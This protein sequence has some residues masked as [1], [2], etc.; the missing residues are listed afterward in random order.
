MIEGSARDGRGSVYWG[1]VG[2]R[3]SDRG[4]GGVGSVC[5]GSR[6]GRE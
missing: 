3:R 6:T 2:R 5:M 1:A 4:R